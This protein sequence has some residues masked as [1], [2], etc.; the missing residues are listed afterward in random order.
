M[1]RDIEWKER[2]DDGVKRTVRIKFLGQGKLKWQFKRSD[3]QLWDY[4]TPPTAGDWETLE[5]KIDQL[6][7]RRRAAFRDLELVQKLRKEHG[8]I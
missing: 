2:L 1:K 6:Y 4:D 5:E 8:S 7:H 3:E